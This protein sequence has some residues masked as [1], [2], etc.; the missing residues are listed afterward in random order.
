MC[1][2][3]GIFHAD[4]SQAASPDLL[5]RMTSILFHRGPD[6]E[7]L[8]VD[9][10]AGLG[11]RRLSIIDVGGGKQPIFNADRSQAIVFN[12]EIYN[13]VPLR[14]QLLQRG[15]RFETRSDTEV[16]LQAY[17]EYGEDCVRHL[18]GMFTFAIWDRQRGRLFVAR[19][20]VGIKPLYYFWDGRTFLFASEIKSILQDPTVSKAV[21]S[22][23]VDDYLTYLYIPAPK[24]IFTAIRKLRP[25]HTLTVTSRGIEEREKEHCGNRVKEDIGDVAP[26]RLQME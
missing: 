24:T 11:H 1:G 15:Y 20:R 13:Y 16:I 9:G 10:P 4:R 25:G 19:D 26:A 7:G 23:A 14:E 22:Q 5:R 21:D 17:N 2:I 8:H 3:A 12:G 6:G 18:R